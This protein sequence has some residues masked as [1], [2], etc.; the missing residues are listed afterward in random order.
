M[1][2]RFALLGS[3]FVCFVVRVGMFWRIGARVGVL[4]GWRLE[5]RVGS[6]SRFGFGSGFG[7]A[8]AVEGCK[9]LTGVTGG[10]EK[11]EGVDIL[12]LMGPWSSAYSRRSRFLTRSGTVGTGSGGAELRLD[13]EDDGV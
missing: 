6:W 12:G 10:R 5:L 7:V 11:G 4:G 8:V 1:Q 3:V 9:F 13:V 2:R